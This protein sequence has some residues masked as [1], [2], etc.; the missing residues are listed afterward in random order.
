MLH[1][2]YPYMASFSDLHRYVSGGAESVQT[3]GHLH[4][5][6]GAEVRQQKSVPVAAAHVSL[7][8]FNSWNKIRKSM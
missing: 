6:P 7:G 3:V 2:L 5:G 1:F 4:A 8:H